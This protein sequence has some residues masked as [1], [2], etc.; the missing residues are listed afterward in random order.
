MF[1][2]FPAM[3]EIKPSLNGDSVSMSINVA[4]HDAPE[5]IVKLLSNLGWKEIGTDPDT[6]EPL[7]QKENA[8]MGIDW[9]A[10]LSSKYWRWYEAMAYEF[11]K[12]VNVGLDA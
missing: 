11:G 5:R 2:Q 6:I 1:T 8:A 12:F 10:D 9:D 7:F 4:P 3:T